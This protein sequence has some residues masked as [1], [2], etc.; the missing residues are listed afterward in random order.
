ML[1]TLVA[2]GSAIKTF[3]DTDRAAERPCPPRRP[4]ASS[5]R[6]ET[7]ATP[8]ADATADADAQAL[9]AALLLEGAREAWH[10]R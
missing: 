9:V 8:T 2:S 1:V 5:V 3:T 4:V 6:R 10:S 7:T